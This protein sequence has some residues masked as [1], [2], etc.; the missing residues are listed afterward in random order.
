MEPRGNAGGGA[1]L[2]VE[3]HATALSRFVDEFTALTGLEPRFDA[4][5]AEALGGLV[6]YLADKPVAPLQLRT[7]RFLAHVRKD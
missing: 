6:R 5:Y 3:D 1:T 7:S 2:A 4:R